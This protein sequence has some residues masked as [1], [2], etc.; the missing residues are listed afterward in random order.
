MVGM[1][2]APEG[3]AIGRNDRGIGNRHAMAVWHGLSVYPSFRENN[4]AI[5]PFRLTPIARPPYS[6][7]GEK[8]KT[9]TRSFCPKGENLLFSFFIFLFVS[10]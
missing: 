1:R 2:H 8:P 6:A 3:I 5:H 4:G 9:K 10:E 7:K